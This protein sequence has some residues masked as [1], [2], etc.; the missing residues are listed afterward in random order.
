ML[1]QRS[2]GKKIFLV[3]Y[4]LAQL[5]FWKQWCLCY[6]LFSK[7]LCKDVGS[8]LDGSRKNYSIQLNQY[9]FCAEMLNSLLLWY[10]ILTIKMLTGTRLWFW[11]IL[12]APH[13]HVNLRGFF[14]HPKWCGTCRKSTNHREG[15]YCSSGPILRIAKGFHRSKQNSYFYFPLQTDILK[16]HNQLHMEIKYV[17]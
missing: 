14:L 11:N 7:G 9:L 16:I 6:C 5:H 4:M 3:C 12:E 1:W 13:G 10:S 8:F 17:Y 2:K 15:S